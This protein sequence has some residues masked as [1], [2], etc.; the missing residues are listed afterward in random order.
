MTIVVP[1]V[2]SCTVN[3]YPFSVVV[4]NLIVE[5]PTIFPKASGSSGY[6]SLSGAAS[7]TRILYGSVNPSLYVKY[8]NAL[9]L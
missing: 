8:P 2:L 9:N 7:A 6:V 4:P 3:E 5:L 1:L